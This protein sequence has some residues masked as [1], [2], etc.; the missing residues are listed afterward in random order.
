[1][2]KL[3]TI[4]SRA[5]E[6]CYLI[7]YADQ[8]KDDHY[9]EL[10]GTYH[11]DQSPFADILFAQLISSQLTKMMGRERHPAVRSIFTDM[12]TKTES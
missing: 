11:P 2:K 5:S 3:L 12:D 1:M 4:T 7:G 8:E 10:A 9:L 6:N